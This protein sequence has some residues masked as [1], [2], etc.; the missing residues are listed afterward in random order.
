MLNQNVHQDSLSV[1][2]MSSHTHVP[3]TLLLGQQIEQVLSLVVSIYW[4]VIVV[5]FL[6]L[7][8]HQRSLQRLPIFLLYHD[9]SARV[10]L[11]VRNVEFFVFVQDYP[12]LV[13]YVE[14]LLHSFR[15]LLLSA[16]LGFLGSRIAHD[17][18][19]NVVAELVVHIFFVHHS[20]I[21]LSPCTRINTVK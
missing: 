14:D 17:L 5:A 1:V 4:L 10:H 11:F 16:F 9:L 20:I 7:G 13:R 15:N 6:V 2:Q 12:V 19:T 3:D 18:G 21:K 8:R